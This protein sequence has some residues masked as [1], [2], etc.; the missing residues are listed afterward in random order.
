MRIDLVINF[1]YESKLVK[2]FVTNFQNDSDFYLQSVF[3]VL[4]TNN[5]S[6]TADQVKADNLNSFLPTV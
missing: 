3:E 2:K 5:D 6:D 1:I 4:E